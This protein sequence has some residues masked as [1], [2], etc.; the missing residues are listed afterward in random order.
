MVRCS[1][2]AI[3]Y[4]SRIECGALGAVFFDCDMD[5]AYA[6]DLPENG[7]EGR[8]KDSRL[9]IPEKID[10]RSRTDVLDRESQLDFH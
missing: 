1:H 7:P 8:I 3:T 4:V 10:Y 5:R 6:G 2:G 9:K